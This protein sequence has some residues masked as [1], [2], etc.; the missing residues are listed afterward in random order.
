MKFIVAHDLNNVIG[1]NGEI[2]WHFKEDFKFFKRMTSGHV[3]IMGTRTYEEIMKRNPNGL[4]NRTMIV[5]SRKDLPNVYTM[6]DVSPEELEKLRVHLNLENLD[7]VFVIGGSATYQAFLPYCK[8][9]YATLI[10]KEYSTDESVNISKFPYTIKFIKSIESS[11]V[12]DRIIENNVE[13]IFNRY[14][15]KSIK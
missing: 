5:L 12:L 14:D 10:N 15:I 2:P 6:K 4:S 3:C 1:I 8:V 13:L 9:L 11:F 7:D